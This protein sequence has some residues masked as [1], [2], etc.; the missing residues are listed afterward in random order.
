MAGKAAITTG[1][2]GA[3]GPAESRAMTAECAQVVLMELS[4]TVH[5]RAKELKEQDF[6]VVA[7][8]GDVSLEDDMAGVAQLAKD[9]YGR[10]DVLW[11][12][13]RLVG[14]D[15]ILQGTDLVGVSCDY[16]M[17]NLEVNAGSVALG[18]RYA[19]PVMAETGGGSITST[20]SVQAAG[21]DLALVA[22]GTS[23]AAIEYMTKSTATSFGHLGIRSNAIAPGLIP[24]PARA[25][26]STKSHR[27]ENAAPTRMA[28]DS[29]VLKHRRIIRLTSL[30]LW[31]FWHR[32]SQSS[33]LARCRTSTAA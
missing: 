25:D 31:C 8:V 4:P 5:K 10:L 29:Q 16:L 33:S 15:W 7:Y 12:N 9:T 3:L 13:A 24:P 20:S 1:A 26:A 21:G 11:N 30:T 32:M 14:A 2:V 22:Y 17:R 23:K 27:L 6:D 18:T 19:V 28:R